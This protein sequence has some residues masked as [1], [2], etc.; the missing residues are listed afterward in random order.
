MLGKGDRDK[1]Q[2]ELADLGAQIQELR[3]MKAPPPKDRAIFDSQLQ[4]LNE[5]KQQVSAYACACRCLLIMVCTQMLVLERAVTAL[6]AGIAE[7]RQHIARQNAQALQVITDAFS[8][9]VVDLVGKEAKL[10]PLDPED[11]EQGVQ[12]LIRGSADNWKDAL[13]ELS[14]AFVCRITSAFGRWL[15]FER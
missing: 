2:A 3:S 1:L 15:R 11:L 7:G 10:L 8:R 4:Q 5:F 14:G 13:I 12:L 6:N 9:L